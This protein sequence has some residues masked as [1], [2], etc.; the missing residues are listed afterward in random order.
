MDITRNQPRDIDTKKEGVPFVLLFANTMKDKPIFKLTHKNIGKIT[1]EEI[2][3]FWVED[4][5]MNDEIISV[6]H[7]EAFRLAN[8]SNYPKPH[9]KNCVLR[10]EVGPIEANPQYIFGN[11]ESQLYVDALTGDVADESPS[12]CNDEPVNDTIVEVNTPL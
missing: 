7:Q 4:M 5:T 8:E 9:S 10:K 6:T 12:F 2:E 3:G 11:L 1:I